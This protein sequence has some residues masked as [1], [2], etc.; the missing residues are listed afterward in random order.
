[1]Q[2]QEVYVFRIFV[3]GASV[4]SVRAVEN[5]RELCGTKLG[6]GAAQ[7][8]VIDVLATPE[9]AEQEK[10]IATPTVM[11]LSPPPSRRVIGDLADFDL[12]AAALGLPHGPAARD[13]HDG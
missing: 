6:S 9:R 8:E 3:S 4:R 11:R 2:S 12:A 13:G 7:I 5:L 10:V 1:M